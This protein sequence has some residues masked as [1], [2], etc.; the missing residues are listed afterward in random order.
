MKNGFVQALAVVWLVVW[1]YQAVPAQSLPEIAKAHTPRLRQ[2]L[3]EN[4]QDFWLKNGLD[5]E[6]GGYVISFDNEGK[7]IAPYTNRQ[8]VLRRPVAVVGTE[9]ILSAALQPSEN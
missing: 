6:H 3:T 2:T 1:F 9:K 8:P 5:K 4:I 7:L